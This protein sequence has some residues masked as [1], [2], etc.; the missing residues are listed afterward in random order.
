MRTLALISMVST[1][2]R[3]LFPIDGVV[4]K[5]IPFFLYFKK[6]FLQFLQYKKATNLWKVKN[7]NWNLYW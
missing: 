3:G 1:G 6:F 4:L 5:K 7:F 2:T